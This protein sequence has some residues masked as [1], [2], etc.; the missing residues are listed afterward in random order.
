MDISFY[1][2]QTAVE[3]SIVAKTFFLFVNLSVQARS[4]R[5]LM[6]LGNLLV[7][8]FLLLC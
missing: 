3:D 1:C 5:L 8:M 7:F 4:T 2:P 6:H